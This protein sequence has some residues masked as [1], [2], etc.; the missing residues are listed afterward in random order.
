MSRRHNHTLTETV[1]YPFILL[2]Y[3]CLN[4]NFSREVDGNLRHGTDHQVGEIVAG[5]IMYALQ[6]TYL[7]FVHY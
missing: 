7:Y 2:M 4:C 6:E 5:N 1:V 3:N